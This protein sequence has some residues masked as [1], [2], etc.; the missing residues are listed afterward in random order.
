DVDVAD[1]LVL[2]DLQGG[3]AEAEAAHEDRAGGVHDG[4]RPPGQGRLGRGVHGVHRE[5]ARHDQL[6]DDLAG[7]VGPL[8]QGDLTPGGLGAHE[9]RGWLLHAPGTP[10]QFC[11]VYVVYYATVIG[12]SSQGLTGGRSVAPPHEG[13]V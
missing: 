1:A 8:A 7:L 11:Y 2:E 4:Q 9:S 10:S 3:V 5:D 12:P 13:V 6:V